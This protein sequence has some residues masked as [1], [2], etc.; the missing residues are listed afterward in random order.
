MNKP[1]ASHFAKELVKHPVHAFGLPTLD[2][3]SALQHLE[4]VASSGKVIDLD[5]L[6]MSLK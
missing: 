5:R 1:T 6:A 3:A 4:D 2:D